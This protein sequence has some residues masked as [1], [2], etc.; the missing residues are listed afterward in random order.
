METPEVKAEFVTVARFLDPAEAQ[1][2]AGALESEG[3]ECFLQGEN[4]NNIV[5]MA[6]RTRLVVN[7]SD[8]AAAREVL[9]AAEAMEPATEG[10]DAV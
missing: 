1:M 4:A 10:D 8:E 3:I 9:D 2:A 6:F 7:G 5:P